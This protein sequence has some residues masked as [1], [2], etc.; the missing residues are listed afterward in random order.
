V[1]LL[2]KLTNISNIKRISFR[3][4][5]N[6]LR[7][8]AVLVVVFYHA[9]LEIFKGGWLG[10]DIFFVISGYLISN[11]IISELNNGTFSFKIFYLRRVKRI[12]PALFSTM[13]LTLPFAYLF[14]TPKAMEEYLDSLTASVFFYANYYFMNVDFYIAESTKLMPLLHTWSLAIEEQYYLLFPLFAF[15]TY[16]YFKKYFTLLIVILTLGSVYIN[17]L[18]QSND[19]FYRLEFRIW[20]L[21][22]G[23]LVMILSNNIKIKHLE[24][25]GLPLMLFPILYFGDNWVNDFEP[26]LIALIGISLIIFSNTETSKLTKFFSYKLISI[27]GLSSYSIYLLHQPVFAFYRVFKANFNLISIRYFDLDLNESINL[28]NN[29]AVDFYN[30]YFN[31]NPLNEFP[32]F[33][34]FLI[35]ITLVLGFYSYKLIEKPSIKNTNLKI[36]IGLFIALS[37]FV[38]LNPSSALENR[39]SNKLTEETV[40]SDYNCWDKYK[41]TDKN[42]EELDGCF[43]D[44]NSNEKLIILG[45]SSTASIAKNIMQN[46]LF[47]NYNIYFSTVYS[48]E[49]F[50]NINYDLACD[51]C[52]LSWIRN[53]PSTIIVSVEIHRFVEAEGMYHSDYYNELNF[54]R[55]KANM[56]NLSKISNEV[57]I[58]EPFPTVPDSVENFRNLLL[59]DQKDQIKEIYLP[60]N[61]WVQNTKATSKLLKGVQVN[62]DIK[63]VETKDLFC[64]NQTN[65]CLIYSGGELFYL[66]PNH[67]SV[68]GGNLITKRIEL[69]LEK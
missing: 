40:V 52:F 47:D 9:E 21:L 62:S 69:L 12:L 55:F 51:N 14:L 39:T 44:N 13:L 8:I 57:Y 31:V 67:L 33:D 29:E 27:I 53:N 66:D 16:K 32:Y 38:L 34:L 48:Q 60:L 56:I 7:A 43:I 36:L 68:T 30:A 11:I 3:E 18:S 50:E 35:L 23:V 26:K 61:S 54:E 20:E 37:S 17:T 58:A 64:L 10:V 45:D 24:K 28:L 46:N 49:F 25:I 15:V 22:L 63:V 19:K 1:K 6:G 59:A 4:D 41:L 42:F 5:I 65:K 2:F